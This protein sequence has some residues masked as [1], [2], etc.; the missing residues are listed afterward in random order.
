MPSHTG[1]TIVVCGATGRQGGAVA[2]HLRAEGWDVRG[3]TRDAAS[4]KAARLAAQGVE[5][6][7]AD[8]ADRPTLDRAFAG[9]Y[10]VYS[11]QNPMLSGFAGEVEQGKNVAD[12]AK[13]AR[14]HHVVY[15]SAGIGSQ[16]GIPSWDTKVEVT[17]HLRALE[18]P[19][20][21][22]RPEAFMEL[23]T[24]KAYYPQVGVWHVM[25]KLMG[26]D[27]VVPWLAVDD[28]G[29]ITARVFAHPERFIGADISLAG[30]LKTIDEC[31]SIWAEVEGRR[32]RSVPMPPWLFARIAGHAGKDLPVM[33]RWLRTGSVPEDRDRRAQSTRARSPSAHG[34][35][36]ACRDLGTQ[37]SAG[38]RTSFHHPV[39]QER[40]AGL[41]TG[42]SA[43]RRAS[44]RSAT[45]SLGLERRVDLPPLAHALEASDREVVAADVLGDTDLRPLFDSRS[46]TTN[47]SRQRPIHPA[48]RHVAHPARA[49]RAR[50]RCA[51]D[52]FL[53][54]RRDRH[55][56]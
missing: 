33:W 47:L 19:L 48:Q 16:T 5:V 38:M 36:G 28:M 15:G 51:H 13:A 7:E 9:A 24:D 55:S 4:D 35:S 56:R 23:M 46:L 31:R 10:G 34:S 18:L 37:C 52:E 11:V 12:A 20:T 44:Q 25:P 49:R 3:L 30:D 21:V 40:P 6:V 1:R 42:C 22:L 32:P 29:A 50:Q 2:R 41:S 27:R 43:A 45:G 53:A 54:V 26:G 8:M 14:V 39:A 17:E